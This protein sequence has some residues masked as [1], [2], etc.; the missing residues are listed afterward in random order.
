MIYISLIK[1][2]I[3][4]HL[5]AVN[6]VLGNILDFESLKLNGSIYFY[7]SSHTSFYINS[8]GLNY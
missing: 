5:K 7:I 8:F 1:F 6:S 3:N 4:L 2:N